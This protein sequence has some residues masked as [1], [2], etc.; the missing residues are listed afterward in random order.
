M[1][2]VKIKG[3]FKSKAIGNI[4]IGMGTILLAHLLISI[5]FANHF[6]FNTTINGVKVSLKTHDEV[7]GIIRSYIK[8]Y[9]L[10]LI[11]RNG[12]KEE[13]EGQNIDFQY[14]EVNSIY[15]IYQ[16][17]NSLT[18]IVS[19]FKKQEHYVEDLFIYSV[20]SLDNKINE[21]NCLKADFVEPKNVSFK[22]SNGSYEIIEEVYGNKIHKDRLKAAIEKGI[23]DGKT[24]LDLDERF[25]Y[26][27]PRYT[28][29]SKK[30][31]E[32]K[33]LLDK[34]ISTKITYIFGSKKEILGG[35]IINQWLCVDENLDVVI[36]K[37]KLIDYVSS[38]SKKYDTVGIERNFRTSL[39]KKVVVKGG[40]YG[41]KIDYAGE[42]K[43]LLKNI[44][45][46]ENSEREPIYAQR[47]LYR[48]E[49]EIGNTYIE[50]NITR[51]RLWFYKNG[52]IIVQGA[53]V[54]GNPN[55][56]NST[57]LGTHM[58]NYKQKGATLIGQDYETEVMYW[59]PFYGN[60]GIHDATWRHSF[61]GDIYKSNGSHGC[62][63]APLYLA[64]RIFENIEEGTPI[65]CYEE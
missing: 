50:V 47:A 3:L 13:I 7:E 11:E 30:T 61:G 15:K 51:Q 45:L 64:K 49:N 57:K 55:R 8:D 23:L 5:Y 9:K 42:T 33:N 24:K 14:N 65:I 38:L 18:W 39:G 10:Q 37:V 43:A 19:L 40:L 22:Y 20:D 26:E 35:N 17:K 29:S 53:V 16:R 28:I 32:T 54:T 27:N 56:G 59:M 4:T 52:R 12:Q 21:L 2:N 25:C 58:L 62:V 31:I 46:G 34:Y 48:G 1:K 36:N 63:N 41:W 44:K 60:I 6:F